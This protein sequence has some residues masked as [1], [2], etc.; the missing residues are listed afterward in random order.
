MSI[1]RCSENLLSELKEEII[2]LLSDV[3]DPEKYPLTLFDLDVLNENRIEIFCSNCSR[4][5]KDNLT[6]TVLC[7]HQ[8][9]IQLKP[10]VKTCSMIFTMGLAVWIR[11][12]EYLLG[13]PAVKV[14]LSLVAGSH[15]LDNE[16]NKRFKDKERLLSALERDEIVQL[17]S[18]MLP[19]ESY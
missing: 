15:D 18:L 11:L 14:H 19:M 3:R 4:N 12:K 6:D 17:I 5:E 13:S 8:V 1:K 9:S 16:V 7:L 10:T 2:Y